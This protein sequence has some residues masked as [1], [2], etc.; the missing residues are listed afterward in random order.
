MV[1]R[2]GQ[3][4]RC[5]QLLLPLPMVWLLVAQAHTLSHSF[6]CSAQTRTE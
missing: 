4:T 2:S 1:S 3:P 5:G 6:N